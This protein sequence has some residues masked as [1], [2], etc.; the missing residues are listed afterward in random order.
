MSNDDVD[1]VIGVAGVTLTVIGMV[2]GFALFVYRLV[3][4]SHTKAE[5][6]EKQALNSRLEVSETQLRQHHERLATLEKNMATRTDVDELEERQ[7]EDT[8]RIESKIDLH[9]SEVLSAIQ[10]LE[11]RLFSLVESLWKKEAK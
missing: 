3:I 7:R 6:A 11:Q 10:T 2:G 9:K 1:V 8:K 5:L 4:R